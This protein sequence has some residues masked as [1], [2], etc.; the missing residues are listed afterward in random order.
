MRATELLMEEHRAIERMLNVL[1][2]IA[3][4]LS[5]GKEV[6]PGDPERAL[7]FLSGFADKCHHAKEE[8]HLFPALVAAGLPQE[9]G[10]IGVMLAEHEQGRAYIAAMREALTNGDHP[11]FAEAAQGYATLLRQHILKEDHVLYPMADARLAAQEDTLVAAYETLEREITGAGGH[12]A[13]HRLLEE[14]LARYA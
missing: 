2:A 5:T 11:A 14:M 1:G 8:G 9:G 4:R 12:E 6:A 3:N 7:D 10:P 13:Y